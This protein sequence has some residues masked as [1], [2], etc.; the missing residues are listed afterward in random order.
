MARLTE[1]LAFLY[2]PA[3][4]ERWAAV[5]TERI[6]RQ[7]L[8]HGLSELVVPDAGLELTDAVKKRIR[9]ARKSDAV[10]SAGNVLRELRRLESPRYTQAAA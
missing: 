6:E 9:A 8:E 2:G 5:F 10:L 3:A 4:A 7:T 1:H